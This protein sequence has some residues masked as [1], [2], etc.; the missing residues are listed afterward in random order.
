MKL[1]EVKDS[2]NEYI[3]ELFSDKRKEPR[4]IQNDKGPDIMK[5]TQT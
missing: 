2:L 4:H 1:N 5:D 3:R